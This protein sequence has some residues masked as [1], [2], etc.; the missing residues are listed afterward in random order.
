MF[1]MKKQNNKYH[2]IATIIQKVFFASTLIII[3]FSLTF[4]IYISILRANE[5]EKTYYQ[6]LHNT[7][8][9]LIVPEL[10]ISNY[11]E[12]KR[13]ISLINK[14][15]HF[16]AVV[17]KEKDVLL[18][19]YNKYELFSSKF[20]LNDNMSCPKEG[21]L[22][23]TGRYKVFCSPIYDT[24]NSVLGL[25]VSFSEKSRPF[26]NMSALI[27]ILFITIFLILIMTIFVRKILTKK[28]AIPFRDMAQAMDSKAEKPLNFSVGIKNYS[29]APTEYN[30]LKKS[31]EHLLEILQKEYEQRNLM[32]KQ[33]ALCNIASQVAH[34]IRSPLAALNAVTKNLPEVDEEKRLLIRR[35]VQRID[36][37]ANDLSSKKVESRGEKSFAP[38]SGVQ[39]SQNLETHLLSSLV[40]P[41]ISEK[42]LQHRSKLGVEIRSDLDEKSYGLFAKVNVKEFKR[43]LSNLI[44]N[45]VEVLEKEGLVKVSLEQKEDKWIQIQVSDNGKGIPPE[46]LSQLAERGNTFGKEG[47]SGLGLYH[48]KTTVEK[49]GGEFKIESVA[50]TEHGTTNGQTH[51]SAPTISGT[52]VTLLLPKEKEPSW[53]VSKIH[54]E[55]KMFLVIVDDDQSIHQIWKERLS[56]LVVAKNRSP[57]LQ[58]FSNPE[59][60]RDWYDL[61]KKKG[62]N[63]LFL[64]DYEFLGSKESGLDVIEDLGLA[65]QTILVTSRYEEK[66]VRERCARLKIKLIPKPLAGFVPIILDPG[67]TACHSVPHCVRDDN[68]KPQPDCILIDDDEIVHTT[69]RLIAKQNGKTIQTYFDPKEFF[70]ECSLYN[71]DIPIYIDA[72]LSKN[73]KG[74]EISKKIKEKGFENIYLATGSSP[75]EFPNLPWIKKIVG[76]EPP[77]VEK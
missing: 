62:L 63:I 44:N 72:H 69:W 4:S 5:D 9:E 53:F 35:A 45:A 1:S 59:Q 21:G 41:L 51:R 49:L 56:K 14:Q 7:L 25:L 8:S 38:T 71:R 28:I 75:K 13:L 11:L 47:G 23:I 17:T 58:N 20:S 34:D 50:P 10:K 39:E 60:L 42:R 55:E 65:K 15:E 70:E 66:D 30:I 24:P 37:I 6:Q 16:I 27:Y 67:S 22:L 76:K 74:E 32:E 48:A 64:C 36:D 54:L 73:Q 43:L 46:I 77:W 68:Q 29:E 52:T 3:L 33:V 57:V 2:S 40:E 18:S 12:I 19:D 31:Y 61:V 26:F